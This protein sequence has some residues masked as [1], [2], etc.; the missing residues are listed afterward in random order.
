MK[1]RKD[2]ENYISFRIIFNDL[3]K[4][5]KLF[6]IV[7]PIVFVLTAIYAKSLPSY[8]VCSVKLAPEYGKSSL[9]GIFGGLGSKYGIL[10]SLFSNDDAFGPLL[11][12]DRVNS[13]DFRV[14][15]FDIQVT[16]DY[17][18]KTFTYYDY[19]KNE[20][21][22]PWWTNLKNKIVAY[23]KPKEQNDAKNTKVDPFRLTKE[24]TE[25]VDII[26]QKVLCY[27]N[28]KNKVITIQVTDQDPLVCA[29]VA[30][31]VKVRLQQFI[32][33]YRTNKSRIDLEYNK[34]LC[35]KAK[36]SYEEAR[37]NY[38]TFSDSNRDVISQRVKSEKE[39]YENEMQLRYNAYA[40]EAAQ[41]ITAEAKVQ[42]DKPAFTTLQSSTVPDDTSGPKRKQMCLFF[43]FFTSMVISAFILYKENH[44]KALLL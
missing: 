31:S 42:E 43:L 20:Q 17:D 22:Y 37:N 36:Y 23:G 12:P 30:D 3:L 35:S 8:Y 1:H 21:W 44:L 14:S 29:T 40:H 5:K 2:E 39:N 41:V 4:H 10:G 16:R 9:K 18:K 33:D 19:L 6:I 24:Q 26:N 13:V 32:T 7:L 27:V 38:V 11:Y 15:L 25:I 28:H 34:K